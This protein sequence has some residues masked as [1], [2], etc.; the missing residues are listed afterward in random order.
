MIYFWGASSGWDIYY[1]MNI[2]T[3]LG[4]LALA[5]ELWLYVVIAFIRS[6]LG[7]QV[8]NILLNEN[9]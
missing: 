3:K 8:H 4:W 1:V 6:H 5:L 7:K 9:G 2:P